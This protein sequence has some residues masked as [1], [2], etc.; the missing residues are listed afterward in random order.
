[1]YSK[2]AYAETDRYLMA[3]I[4]KTIQL[5]HRI[6]GLVQV[7]EWSWKIAA[8]YLR[9]NGSFTGTISED[10]VSNVCQ[11]FKNLYGEHYDEKRTFVVSVVSVERAINISQA[12]LEQYKVIMRLADDPVRVTSTSPNNPQ[13]SAM[14]RFIVNRKL[15]K[16]KSKF[17]EHV[18]S[19]LLFKSVIFTSTTLYKACSV[20]RHHSGN[21][22]S[23]LQE[24]LKVGLIIAFDNGTVSST[25]KAI[26]Y[27]KWL[28]NITNPL[29]CQRFEQML[30]SFDDDRI[31]ADSVIACTTAVTLLPHKARP[32]LVVLNYLTGDRYS[33]LQLDFNEDHTVS[34]SK[35]DVSDADEESNTSTVMLDGN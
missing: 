18:R 28:P 26:V 2:L 13:H 8:E 4:G 25:K 17:G 3:K 10:F 12:L 1:M 15:E 23:V 27:A 24:L 22:K 32:K 6:V 35:A 21:V 9:I 19:I 14:K 5:T 34:E 11:I 31:S 7:L 30:A 29:E 33:R 20:F 16:S